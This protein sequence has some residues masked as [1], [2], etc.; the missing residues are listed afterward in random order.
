MPLP[1]ASQ[2]QGFIS[3]RAHR[4]RRLLVAFLI[5]VS[6]VAVFGFLVAP[7]WVRK[8][9][10]DVLSAQLHRPVRV[11]GVRINPFALSATVSGLSISEPAGGAEAM[12]FDRLYANVELQSLFR[13][14]P[15]L[16]EVSL[17]GPRVVIRRGNDGRYNWQDLIDQALAPPETPA[18]PGEPLRFAVYNIQLKGGR[19]TFDD[20]AEGVVHKIE[21]LE[22]GV[23]FISS[24]P[25]QVDV[26]VEPVI[27]AR[28]NG[29]PFGVHGTTLPFAAGRDTTL[30]IG[31]DALDLTPYV[32]YSPVEPAFKIPS[33][34][35]S[36]D[37]TLRFSQPQ[38]GPPRVGLK[39]SVTL[40]ALEVQDKA[41]QP[42][43]KLD[44]LGLEIADADLLGRKLHLAQVRLEHPELALKRS[45]AGGLNLLELLPA[46]VPAP[47]AAVVAAPVPVAP[48]APAPP[49]T[50]QVDRIELVE[51]DVTVHDA[52]VQ[53]AF[54]ARVQPLAATVVGL[55][56]DAGATAQV[57]VSLAMDQGEKFTHLGELQLAPLQ[58]SG[59][60][61]L[62]SLHLARFGAYLRPALPGGSIEGGKL[63]A[64]LGYKFAAGEG[65]PAIHLSLPSAALADL[66]VRRQGAKDALFKLGRLEMAEGAI[67]VA[68]RQVSLA[69]LGVDAL[70]LALV[71]NKGG[72]LD[73]LDLLG[74]EAGEAPKATARPTPP[75]R[76]KGGG[77]SK[78]E[79]EWTVSLAE[80]A[81]KGSSVRLED[82]TVERPVVMLAEQLGI[83]V[84]GFSSKPG[85][86][87][88]VSL[89]SRINKNGK[90]KI[91]GQVGLAP[92]TADL[93][94]DLQGVD[95]LPANPYLSEYLYAS[96]SRGRLTSRGKLALEVP[97]NGGPPKGGFRGDVRFQ[98]FAAIDRISASDFVKW[99]S[100][101][102]AQVDL[103]LAPFA[104]VIRE[105]ALTDFY[106]RLILSEKGELNLREITARQEDEIEGKKRAPVVKE[107]TAPLVEVKRPTEG[108]AEGQVAPPPEPPP[109]IRIDRI[110]L[111]GGNIA[112]SD[113]FIKPN[114][115]ANLTG[116][117]GTVA[118]LSSDPSTIAELDLAGKVDNSAPVTVVG[119]LNPFRQDRYLDI[120]AE[121]KG[122]DLPGLS[123]YSGKYVGYGI[124]KGK[125]SAMLGYKVEDRKLTA[126][127]H[128]FLDQ[129]TFGD[130]VES[131]DALKLPVQLAVSLLKNGRGEIDIDLPI[132]GSLDDPQ[133][134]VGGIVF[135]ALVNL[136][137]KA[138]TA[139]FSLLGSLFAGGA[140]L[141][142]IQ[143]DAG[144]AA[145][146][147]TALEKL[148]AISKALGDRPALKVEFAGRVD[149]A[150]DV[151]GL[152]REA[153]RQRMAA[154]KIKDLVKKGEAAP[155]LDDVLIAPAEYSAL[156][157]RVYKDGDFK[158]PRNLIGLAKDLPD[159]E[160]ESLLLQNTAVGAEDLRSLGQR[161]AQRVE[162]WLTSEG[163]VAPERLFV[164]APRMEADGK[165]PSVKSSR[166]DF[167]IK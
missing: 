88:R 49:F 112:Y 160:M 109:P 138:V 56:N 163:K 96:L 51:G 40:A 10:E 123:S 144:L 95:L 84:Q 37:L 154:L 81:L 77:G 104:L 65:A 87:A 13:R 97:A 21:D 120:R 38:D 35:L 20:Q 11:E 91:G 113:R 58:A 75:A 53:P 108:H 76:G 119:K 111:K 146:S 117:A 132:S 36:T 124:E 152:K 137:V 89:D 12:G 92:L 39:G 62:A 60:I 71:R 7:P 25:S 101:S 63:E 4:H 165:D 156:L 44:R 110:V 93:D 42:V 158:K 166:V 100:F 52:A 26:H 114:Y 17:E 14:G 31:L 135:R 80:L 22:I 8:T 129:L 149:P 133:F 122:F 125:L 164:L 130:K 94:L 161:R 33:A 72:R 153:I 64:Q 157:K 106:T 116:M 105:I 102:F 45:E 141:S 142:Y 67:D 34:R 48:V 86:K 46:P 83:S 118:G 140:D 85:N 24:I 50:F 147:P 143:F 131:P 150:T 55:S 162:D 74:P 121:M 145:L 78:A 29:R 19:I 128:I 2:V 139:P 66:A 32:A 57:Q 16:G 9:A 23:P 28:I 43:V 159:A 115:D 1:S 107:G 148:S 41:G 70:Q 5:L 134:S 126:T 127:N 79:P 136:I 54:V 90:V 73:A 3:A 103:R 155:S 47:A 6:L 98:D 151:E 59:S 99:K 15:V 27:K 30:A 61:T 69:R 68:A 18:P 82:R 167:A